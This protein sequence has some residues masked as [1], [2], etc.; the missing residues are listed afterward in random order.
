MPLEEHGDAGKL[1]ETADFTH[2]SL[3]F[4]YNVNDH[5]GLDAKPKLPELFW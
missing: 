3:K 5:L 4:R 1:N 2:E